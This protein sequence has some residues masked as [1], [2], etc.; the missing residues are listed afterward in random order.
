[1]ELLDNLNDTTVGFLSRKKVH[2]FLYTE[3][4]CLGIVFQNFYDFFKSVLGDSF[5]TVIDVL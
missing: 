2:I 4:L 5:L 3:K 1:M